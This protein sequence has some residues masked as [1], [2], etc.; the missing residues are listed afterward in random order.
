MEVTELAYGRDRLRLRQLALK[1]LAR[2]S[3][4]GVIALNRLP[5]HSKLPLVKIDKNKLAPDRT[6]HGLEGVCVGFA[7]EDKNL[8][9]RLVCA[10]RE[11]DVADGQ[12]EDP[13]ALAALTEVQ[14]TG[15]RSVCRGC[16]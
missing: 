13:V 7:A 6:H 9:M 3:Y 4:L 12:E 8:V 15:P 16:G 10:R 11:R 1:H 5:Q 2:I 14:G